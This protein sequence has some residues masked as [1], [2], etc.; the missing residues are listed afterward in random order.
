MSIPKEVPSPMGQPWEHD[1]KAIPGEVVTSV[2]N[3]HSKK[4]DPIYVDVTPGQCAGGHNNSQSVKKNGRW[5]VHSSM[6]MD[7]D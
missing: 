3:T 5:N 1:R 7:D 6:G 4:P 2:L